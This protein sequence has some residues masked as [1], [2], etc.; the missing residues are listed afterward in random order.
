[1]AKSRLT[2]HV[3]HRL[4]SGLLVLVPIGV[5]LLVLSFIFRAT[6]GVL[7]SLFGAFLADGQAAAD[8]V[9]DP[10]EPTA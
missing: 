9:D 6:V 5:T 2:T 3:V 1:M 10:E 7:V 4:V 8:A